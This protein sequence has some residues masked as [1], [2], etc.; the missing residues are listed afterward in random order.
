LH[1][2]SFIK[3]KKY[4][5][6]PPSSLQTPTFHQ[7]CSLWHRLISHLLKR[8][9]KN[10]SPP[11]DQSKLPPRDL[12][13]NTPLGESIGSAEDKQTLSREN[14]ELLAHFNALSGEQR[15]EILKN[16]RAGKEEE[17]FFETKKED[18]TVVASADEIAKA[19][20]YDNIMAERRK[21]DLKI[22]YGSANVPSHSLASGLH[23]TLSSC[24]D[25]D[26]NATRIIIRKEERGSE[27]ITRKKTQDKVV[28]SLSPKISAGNL[29]R[30]LTSNDIADYHVAAD[31]LSWQS[32]LKNI[33]TF[34]TQYDMVSLLLI[35]QDVDLSKPHLVAKA[36][37]FKDAIEDWHSLDD[38]H[39]FEWQEFLLR[40]GSNEETTSDNWLEEVLLLL[41]EPT[42][43]AEVES[44]MVSMPKQQRGVITTLHFIIKRMVVKNQEAKDAL[45]IYIKDFNITKFPGENVPT[46]C[47]H[48]KAIARA[49]GDGNLP[50]NTTRKV[51]KGFAK[52]STKSFNDFYSSQ[53]ALRRGCFY[54]DIMK[55]KSIQSQLCNLLNDIEMTYLDLVGGNKWDGKV[56]SPTPSS[57]VANGPF[58]DGDEHEACALAAKSNIPWDDWVK[59]YAKCH[60]CG[61]KGHIRP[62]CPD[63]LK[64]LESGEIKRPFRPSI[65]QPRPTNRGVPQPHRQNVMKDPKMKASLSAFNALFNEKASKEGDEENSQSDV[66]DHAEEDIDDDVY[67]FLAKVGSLKE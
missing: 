19:E 53:I 18:E 8:M 6:L 30:L 48:L 23:I 9:T 3:S 10:E 45:E 50:S 5:A 25:R 42:L 33:C 15:S 1:S 21:Q 7:D 40:Y 59:L 44:D 64:K 4:N 37:H 31:A 62:H 38:N 49:L 58:I 14:E 63:Y 12:I 43:R 46:A 52:S 54:T 34:C 61:A 41:M 20:L 26:L 17:E 51:L 66:D 16:L 55:G 57:F 28:K 67:N 56:A 36:R 29:S 60:H 2:Y 27:A 32:S 35:P 13:G 47:L 11:T 39:Y 24:N 65:N 22:K